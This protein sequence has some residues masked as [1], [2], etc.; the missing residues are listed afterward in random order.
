MLNRASFAD[1]VKSLPFYVLPHHFLSRIV[2]K[3]TRVRSKKW[4]P[5]VIRHFAKAFQVN[6]SEAEQPDP[7]AYETF[8]VFFTRPLKKGLRPI[9]QG[10]KYIASPVDGAISQCGAITQGRIIQA[11]GQDYTV[12][13]LLGGLVET[14]APFIN[15]QFA[16]IYLSPRDYHRIHMP[17]DGRLCEQIYIPGRLFSVAGFTARAIPRVFARNERVVALFDTAFGKMAMVLVGAMNVAAIETVWAGLITPPHRHAI[18]RDIYDQIKLEKG[19]EMGRFNMG[20]TVILLFESANLQ[21]SEGCA[22][23]IPVRLGELLAEFA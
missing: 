15:G 4:V 20:S 6:L 11:K 21:W 16:T 13:E 1:Y 19:Q 18:K 3:L 10:E 2:F 12:Q 22:P 9:V 8:N 7:Q 5:V 17:Y 14:A 23:D